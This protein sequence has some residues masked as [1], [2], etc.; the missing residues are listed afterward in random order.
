MQ[1]PFKFNF[2]KGTS[3][4]LNY[5]NSFEYMERLKEICIKVMKQDILDEADL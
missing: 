1:I 5:A 4:Y 3:K 2:S